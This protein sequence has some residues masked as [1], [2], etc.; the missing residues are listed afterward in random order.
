MP[1]TRVN[2]HLSWH[3]LCDMC[4]ILWRE[5]EAMAA[6]GFC[7]ACLHATHAEIDLGLRQ[8]V[9]YLTRWAE[10]TAWCETR[11]LVAC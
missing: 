1:P 7:V 3:D 4:C 2:R 11:G 8:L 5:K 6:R 9:Q 10:F